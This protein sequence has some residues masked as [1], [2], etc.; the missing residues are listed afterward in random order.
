M[1]NAP[2]SSEGDMQ[3]DFMCANTTFI[4]QPMGEGVI[5][6][7]KSYYLRNKLCVT[8]SDVDKWFLSWITAK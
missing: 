4:L 6:T 3:W 7:F 5:L 1:D 2:K 8:I